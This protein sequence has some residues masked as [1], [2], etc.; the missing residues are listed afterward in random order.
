MTDVLVDR[1][2]QDVFNRL[3][4]NS[5]ACFS[6]V[7]LATLA[8]HAENDES[9][10]EL[11]GR[12]LDIPLEFFRKLCCRRRRLSALGCWRPSNRTGKPRCGSFW[13]R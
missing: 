1:G 11:L 7:G 4:G 13:Q 6:E 5:C 8:K 12:R 9:L 2:N 3:A 10:A